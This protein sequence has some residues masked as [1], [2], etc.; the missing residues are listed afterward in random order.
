MNDKKVYSAK[1]ASAYLGISLSLICRMAR[2]RRI[3][4]FRIGK[5]VKFDKADLE[6]WI[7]EQKEL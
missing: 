5:L 4:S 7:N 3:P 1:E 6:A 2:E